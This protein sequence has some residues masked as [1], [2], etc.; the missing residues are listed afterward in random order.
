MAGKDDTQPATV[1][2]PLAEVAPSPTS[3]TTAAQPAAQTLTVDGPE[4]HRP[5]PLQ[6]RW[7]GV[8]H[9]VHVRLACSWVKPRVPI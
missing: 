3:T 8:S 9:V 7:E 5:Q 2:I 1:D 4:A 6:L